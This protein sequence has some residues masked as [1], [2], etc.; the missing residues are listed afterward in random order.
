LAVA[1]VAPWPVQAQ[2]ARQ[3]VIPFESATVSIADV[4]NGTK[5]TKLTLAGY[6]QVPKAGPKQPAVILMHGANGI[7]VSGAPIGEWMRVLNGA[8]FATFTIDSFAARG[9]HSMAD[10]AKLP[11][12]TRLPDA[13]G[14][15]RA[16]A[17][18]PLI[19]AKKIAVMGL[20]HGGIP[21]LYSN[22][23]RFQK[24]YGDA[25]FAAHISVY[26]ACGMKLRDDERLANPLL[27][28]HGLADNWVPAEP[29]REYATRLRT[30]GNNIRL[31]EYPDAHHVF[32]GPV[33]ATLTTFN[34]ATTPAWCRVEESDGGILLN[35]ET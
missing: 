6:L 27:M 28:L 31:F 5:G 17:N 18:H 2:L 35:S 30:A 29:C 14:A 20:S 12:I 15:Y 4:L 8:G 32:D 7:G 19:D 16:L 10:V 1:L 33:L 24:M 26:G 3:E 9:L 21:A 34:N 13:F 11:A 25:K 23:V 22:L